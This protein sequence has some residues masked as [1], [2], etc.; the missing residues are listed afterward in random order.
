M[1]TDNDVLTHIGGLP[2]AL[3]QGIRQVEQEA[4]Q[5]IQNAAEKSVSYVFKVQE[6]TKAI[7]EFEDQITAGLQALELDTKLLKSATKK[8]QFSGGGNVATI[9]LP[10]AATFA[11]SRPVIQEIT[12]EEADLRLGHLLGWSD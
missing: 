3:L 11:Y 5:A 2:I 8:L 6:R 12:E 10:I 4:S 7:Q 9:Q 1:H